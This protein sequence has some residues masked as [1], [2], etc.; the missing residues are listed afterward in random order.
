MFPGSVKS[1]GYTPTPFARFPFT[2]PTVRHCVPSHFNWSSTSWTGGRSG[3]ATCLNTAVKTSTLSPPE[4]KIQPLVTQSYSSY[5]ETCRF[6][7]HIH[8]RRRTFTFLVSVYSS[9]PNT[10]LQN[11]III[12]F[13]HGLGRLTCSGIDALPSF[14]GASTISSSSR[15]VVEGVFRQ[16]GV[17]RS[18]KVADPVL[19]VFES[20]VLYSRDL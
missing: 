15:F 16:S 19:F 2:S 6:Q 18:F 7:T 20:H 17:V 9:D 3:P 4:T 12:I 8:T 13:L 1:T 14:P 5:S 10:C 11:F